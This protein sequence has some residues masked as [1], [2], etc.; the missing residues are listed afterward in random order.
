MNAIPIAAT[1]LAA[2]LYTGAK[3]H[4]FYNV[5]APVQTTRAEPQLLCSVENVAIRVKDVPCTLTESRPTDEQVVLSFVINGNTFAF[6]GVYTDEGIEAQAAKYNDSPGVPVFG[7]CEVGDGE[8]SCKVT[9]GTELM[10]I[11]AAYNGPI[12]DV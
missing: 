7:L 1:V 10:S 5:P 3:V 12:S 4:D 9:N 6:Y 8:G 11:S 2:V